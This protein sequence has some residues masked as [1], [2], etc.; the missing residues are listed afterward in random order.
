MHLGSKTI[1]PEYNWK[2]FYF[3]GFQGPLLHKVLL[4]FKVLLEIMDQSQFNFLF[5][6]FNW[7]MIALQ[8]WVGFCRVSAWICRRFA[9][10]P[11]LVTPP[12]SSPS[13]PSGLTQSPGPSFPSHTANSPWPSMLHTMHMFPCHSLHP[14]D[15]LFPSTPCVYEIC[16]LCLSLDCCP[17]NWFI[18][19][20]F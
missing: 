6:Y 1:K 12:T 13:H 9:Y 19:A 8:Y 2:V 14:S 10:V 18:C 17:A 7:R 11:S 15:P 4:E 3:F 5:I 20:I 16:S